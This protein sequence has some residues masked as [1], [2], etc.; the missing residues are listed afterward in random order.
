MTAIL[1]WNIQ[2]GQGCDGRVDLG[3]IAAVVANMGGADI[4]CFQ[5]VTRFYPEVDGR[6]ADQVAHLGALLP[7]YAAIFGPA[8]DRLGEGNAPRRQFGNLI[9]SRLPVSQAFVHPLPQPA[10]GGIK[11]MPRAAVEAT[12]ETPEGPLRIVTMHLEYHSARQRAAQIARVRAL[13]A[14]VAVNAATPPLD[15]GQGIYA[16][17]VRPA[18]AVLC[19]DLNLLPGDSEYAALFAPFDDGTPPLKDA[20]RVARADEP[21]PPSCGLFDRAQWPEGGHCRDYFAVTPDVAARVRS[22]ECDVRADASDHQPVRIVL[23][24]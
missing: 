21:H 17:P 9:L 22:I 4:L 14:E 13:H 10:Q 6:G 24:D 23:S 15:P 8:V 3:R 12:V 19:G 2:W 1:S 20:W 7:G 16:A 11:H 5:E 18:S